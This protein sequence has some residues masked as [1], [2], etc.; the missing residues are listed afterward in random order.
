MEQ[1]VH[2]GFSREHFSCI[3]DQPWAGVGVGS[4]AINLPCPTG[5]A[6]FNLAIGALVAELKLLTAY[7]AI[8]TISCIG[9]EGYIGRRRPI[10]K[11]GLLEGYV[12]L[13]K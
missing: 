12:S 7:S 9:S 10:R 4:Q 1:F 5:I 11:E 6:L 8:P 2:F 13:G 3:R